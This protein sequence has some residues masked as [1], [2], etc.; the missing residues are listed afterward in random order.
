MN[1]KHYLLKLTW[2]GG[3]Q[4]RRQK[5]LVTLTSHFNSK[6]KQKTNLWT[7]SLEEQQSKLDVRVAIISVIGVVDFVVG[8]IIDVVLGVG[9]VGAI[10]VIANI[11]IRKD[12]YKFSRN[13]SSTIE[14][15]G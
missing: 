10:A 14:W 1:I 13:F 12:K 2:C 6:S 15:T 4:A 5:Q 9:L 8:I 7:R 3:E 11:V